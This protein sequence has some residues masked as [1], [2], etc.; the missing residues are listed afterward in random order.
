MAEYQEN[1]MFRILMFLEAMW[2]RTKNEY[3]ENGTIAPHF[4]V[5]TDKAVDGANMV[6]GTELPSLYNLEGMEWMIAKLK[7]KVIIATFF[8]KL[9]ED[10]VEP[11]VSFYVEHIVD[12]DGNDKITTHQSLIGGEEY[13]RT[14][15]VVRDK[16][17][18]NEDG[19]ILSSIDIVEVEQ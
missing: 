13:I 12:E 15:N 17:N 9:K 2:E 7:A 8:E 16:A 5:L 18:V 1:K 11:I 4:Y 3:K 14:F 19:T 10:D 6:C